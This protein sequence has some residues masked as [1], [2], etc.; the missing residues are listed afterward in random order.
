MLERQLH[1]AQDFIQNAPTSPAAP[2]P[3]SGFVHGREAD[4][5]S[6]PVSVIHILDV[7]DIA[8]RIWGI[9]DRLSAT[10][11]LADKPH[12]LNRRTSAQRVYVLTILPP[13]AALSVGL[14]AQRVI[15]QRFSALA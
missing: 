4:G 8:F 12:R 9:A 10:T 3:R 7:A 1:P 11:M 13:V 5:A 2:I 14:P 6:W 15:A